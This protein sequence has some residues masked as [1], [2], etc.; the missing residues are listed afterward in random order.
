MAI[1]VT[2][3]S[4]GKT[5]QAPDTAA[6]KKAPCLG[7][8]ELLPIPAAAA[9]AIV[10]KRCTECGVDVNGH[11]RTKD[12]AGRYYCQACWAAKLAAGQA[13]T[14]SRQPAPSLPLTDDVQTL[15]E[16][17]DCGL[18]FPAGELVPDENGRMVC[19]SCS[20]K[21]FDLAPSPDPMPLP[22]TAFA[23]PVVPVPAMPVLPYRAPQPV[24]PRRASGANHTGQMLAGGAICLVGIVVT[25]GTY[26]AA[27][28]GGGGRYTIAWG[29]IVFGGI[30]FFQGLT[31]M[32]SDR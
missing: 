26:L 15:E 12:T 29:A 28:A 23:G 24:Q 10:E 31:G 11:K 8:G 3:R 1:V 17:A 32:M 25:A 6:G 5:S 16:C 27:S 19:A 21:E 20:R 9:G 13:T 2:C 30:R 22:A 7:C 18:S 14:I 4:C